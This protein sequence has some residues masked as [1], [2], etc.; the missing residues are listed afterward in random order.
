MK[1][2]ENFLPVF[3]VFLV[4]SFLVF[5]LSKAGILN[6]VSSVLQ[7]VIS[8][9]QS[10]TYNFFNSV[11]LL[12]ENPK[13]KKLER[14]NLILTS[15]LSDQKKLES[16]NSALSDQFQVSSPNSNTLLPAN[17]VGAPSFIPGVSVPETFIIDKGTRD[18]VRV[19]EAVIYKNN[20][21]GKI[22][23]SNDSLSEVTLVTNLSS[24]FTVKT[25]SSQALGVIKGQGGGEMILD[26]VLLSDSLKPSDLVL[27]NGDTSLDGAGYPPDLVVGKIISVDKKASS[28]F[29]RAE[30]SSFIDFSKIITV[31]IIV[32]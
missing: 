7:K 1:R 15:M 18:R 14:E 16:E 11:T 8:P 32:K 24:S 12:G 5:G 23:K 28:L 27:T 6:P 21:L 9:F 22:T 3:F 2:K 4:L 29:Q 13:L 10:A 19:G 26:N 25:S 20:L 30:V 31:F 17:I